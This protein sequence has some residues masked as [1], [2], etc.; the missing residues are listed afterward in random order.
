VG[1]DCDGLENI[2]VGEACVFRPLYDW[3][4]GLLRRRQTEQKTTGIKLPQISGH[5][6]S[7][8]TD[9]DGDDDDGDDDGDGDDYGDMYQILCIIIFKLPSYYY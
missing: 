6:T 4:R 9:G 8:G 3:Q 1:F 5:Q 2:R 7:D